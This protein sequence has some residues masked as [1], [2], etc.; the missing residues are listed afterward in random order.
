MD[1]RSL[2]KLAGLMTISLSSVL[3]TP[4][5]FSDINTGTNSEDRFWINRTHQNLGKVNN[6]QA[7]IEQ[8]I[9]NKPSAIVSDVSFQKPNEFYQKVTQPD[10]LKGF[11]A[12]YRNNTI[13]L[14]HVLR[15]QAIEIKGLQE[16]KNDSS[17]ERVK[18]VYL[19]NKEHYDQ[20]FTPSIH[21]ADRLSVGIDFMAKDDNLEIRKVE[22]FV[23]YHHSLFMQANFIFNNGLESKIKNSSMEFNKENLLIPAINLP[24]D[25]ETY[26]WDFSKKH[27]SKNKVSKKVDPA[28]IWPEDKEN[29]WNFKAYEFY[30]YGGKKNAAAYYY[31]DNF[32]LITLTKPRN[33]VKLTNIGVSLTLENIKVALNQ[34]PAFTNLEFEYNGIHY[35]LVSNAHPESLITMVKDMIK[36]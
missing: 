25:T 24:D 29:N 27:L 10:S 22:G 34:F 36:N 5:S 8:T 14:H 30:Q 11:E 28:I 12:S 3:L 18:G 23:D 16:Y 15:K 31:S 7:V 21:V 35:T 26:A 4:L 19:Y 2:I 32:F 13:T 17:L 20:E 33:S 6:F 1:I 9:S